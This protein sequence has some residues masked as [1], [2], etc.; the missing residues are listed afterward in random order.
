MVPQ[1]L[2]YA[3]MRESSNCGHR[4]C[5]WHM[6]SCIPGQKWQSRDGALPIRL[7]LCI[8][9][10]VPQ[11]AWRQCCALWGVMQCAVVWSA[12]CG[13][14]GALVEVVCGVWVGN[15]MGLESS[16]VGGGGMSAVGCERC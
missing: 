16:S 8:V 1:M 9:G 15:R 12:E 13:A 2:L 11:S 14:A 7:S 10:K 3:V 5:Q 6:C 4:H